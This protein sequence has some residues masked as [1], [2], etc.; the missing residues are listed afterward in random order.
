LHAVLLA[1]GF[2]LG[3]VDVADD[4]AFVIGESLTELLPRRRKRL[5]VTT[6][7]IFRKF[8]TRQSSRVNLTPNKTR[9]ASQPART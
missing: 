4:D 8:T 7:A 3:A 6:P 1:E 5:A 9:I 2:L